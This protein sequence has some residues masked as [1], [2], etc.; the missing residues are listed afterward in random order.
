MSKIE[1]STNFFFFFFFFKKNILWDFEQ[2]L[3]FRGNFHTLIVDKNVINQILF[4][5][6]LFATSVNS[7]FNHEK[8]SM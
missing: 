4:L 6:K 3:Y 5:L 1:S 7:I 8:N 2:V